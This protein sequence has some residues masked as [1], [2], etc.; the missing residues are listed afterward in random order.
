[1]IM[2]NGKETGYNSSPTLG[3]IKGNMC[4]REGSMTSAVSRSDWTGTRSER[5]S[6]MQDIQVFRLLPGTDKLTHTDATQRSRWEGD[7]GCRL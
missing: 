1:M 7:S 6:S 5:V 4:Q 3:A 2:T